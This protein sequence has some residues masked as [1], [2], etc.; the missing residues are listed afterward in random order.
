[1]DIGMQYP[2]LW[3]LIAQSADNTQAKEITMRENESVQSIVWIIGEETPR[4]IG[5]RTGDQIS[6]V[7]GESTM[8]TGDW[9]P[10]VDLRMEEET[11]LNL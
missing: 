8:G 3:N 9:I 10:I 7:G 11:V 4:I 2:S 1:M 5:I 6:I